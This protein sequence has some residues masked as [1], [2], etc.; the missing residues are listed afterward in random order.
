MQSRAGKEIPPDYRKIV[1]LQIDELGWRYNA[2]KKHPTLYPADPNQPPL[3]V[4]TTPSDHRGLS[5]FKTALRQ[6]GGALS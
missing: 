4:P 3:T 5:N 1:N 2:G 6:R